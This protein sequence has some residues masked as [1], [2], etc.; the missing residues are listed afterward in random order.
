MIDEL[1]RELSAAGIRGRPRSR[2][3]AEASDH[4]SCDPEARFGEPRAI[5]AQFAEELGTVEARR[6][7]RGSFAALALAGVAYALAFWKLQAS[8]PVDILGGRHAGLGFA[9]AI[10]LILLPQ[11]SFVA[12]LLAPLSSSSRVAVRRAALGLAA[13]AG[14]LACALVFA[15]EFRLH[16]AV[17]WTLAPAGAALLA[18]GAVTVRAARIRTTAPARDLEL[19]WRFALL[20]AALAALA[21][22]IAGSTGGD[23]GEGIRN[24]LVESVAC[25]SG[26][27][28]LGK[29]MGL[30]R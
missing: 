18:A 1:A 3:L 22:G 30:R 19:P 12:G 23:P 29:Y 24:A 2:I 14:S 16:T 6:A 20:V 8:P 15:W 21:V 27:A 28:L 13:G 4:M 25:M 10:G 26:F 17:L 7:A 9:A 5:A 11:V